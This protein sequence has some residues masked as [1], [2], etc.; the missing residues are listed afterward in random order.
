MPAADSR[1]SIRPTNFTFM[2][3]KIILRGL[4]V[5]L[6]M[7]ALG[8]LINQTHLGDLLNQGW[9][10][11]EVRGKGVSG[12]LLFLAI[13]MLFTAIGLPRQ[14]IA[15]MAGYAFGFLYGT[16]LGLIAT[17]LGCAATFFY[18]RFTG[19]SL[20]A[21]RL[22]GRVAKIDNFVRDY[23]FT[24]TLLIRLLPVGSNVA[25]SLAGGVS[26]VPAAPFLLG[27]ALGFLPQT[28]IFALVGSGVNV[29]PAWRI[30]TAIA[31]F[32]GSGA[33]GVYLFRRLRH[34]R[35]YDEALERELGETGADPDLP[36]N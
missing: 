6:S 36:V 23:P 17:E 11:R 9:I 29:D 8:F 33:L 2:N 25:T 15:F 10:D 30:G 14:V 12:E 35:H 26:S 24:M 27:S 3:P 1:F 18:A 7:A 16:W 22:S 20:V 13:G 28:A 32:I 4:A 5:L 31:L 34:G 19:R 21:K